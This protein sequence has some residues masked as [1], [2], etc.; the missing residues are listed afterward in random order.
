M[1]PKSRLEA[2]VADVL[3]PEEAAELERRLSSLS[4]VDQRPGRRAK[5][6]V[7]WRPFNE[8]L[9]RSLQDP[10]VKSAYDALQGLPD[11]T[12]MVCEEHPKLPWPH[13]DCIGPG[14]PVPTEPIIISVRTSADLGAEERHT[15]GTAIGK[16][17]RDE[18][19][20][21]VTHVFVTDK[22]GSV[23]IGADRPYP[24]TGIL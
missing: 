9:A 5:K 4:P 23:T 6:G 15:L 11:D 12:D 14:M 22:L 18:L 24:G 10:E 2:L 19:G 16:Y 20:Y 3:T 21:E 1:E 8:V 17:V 7:E 13:D